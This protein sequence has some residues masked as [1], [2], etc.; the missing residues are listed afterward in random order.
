MATYSSKSTSAKKSKVKQMTVKEALSIFAAAQAAAAHTLTQ[1]LE[2]ANDDDDVQLVQPTTPKADEP[3]Q[4][5]TEGKSKVKGK[6]SAGMNAALSFLNRVLDDNGIAKE[7]GLT[8]SVIMNA[9]GLSHTSQLQLQSRNMFAKLTIAE[10]FEKSRDDYDKV[11]HK[12]PAAVQAKIKEI[13]RPK[14]GAAAEPSTPPESTTTTGKRTLPEEFAAAA[15]AEE[16]MAVALPKKAMTRTQVLT[17]PATPQDEDDLPPP[18]L[19]PLVSPTFATASTTS[20]PLE[21]TQETATPDTA[22][23]PA[24]FKHEMGTLKVYSKEARAAI[25]L[26]PDEWLEA[27]LGSMNYYYKRNAEYQVSFV[28][29]N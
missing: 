13:V 22:R 11:A 1:N 8:A 23:R 12:L 9:F 26:D 3:L 28:D 4:P 10:A 17:S 29:E 18:P 5:T 16:A 2:L 27:P 15:A 19:S 6:L 7:A 20:Q 24:L 14:T 21:K 25:Y